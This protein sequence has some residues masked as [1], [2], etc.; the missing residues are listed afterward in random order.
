[1]DL[2]AKTVLGMLGKVHFLIPQ[3]NSNPAL[4]GLYLEI[5]PHGMTMTTTDGHSLAQAGTMRYNLQD[6]RRWLI[7]RRAIFEVKKLL[8]NAQDVT[9]FLGLCGN[10]LVFSGETFNFFT[11]LLVDPFPEY[12]AILERSEFLPAVVDRAE[13]VKTLRRSSCLLSGQFIATNFGFTQEALHVSIENKEVG[14]LAEKLSLDDFNGDAVDIRFYAPYLLSGLQV[15]GE[16]K[17]KFFL[18]NATKPIVFESDQDDIHLVYLVMPV[19]PV[20]TARD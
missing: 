14:A 12:A 15:F 1:M 5:T 8:E 11:K 4:N 16:E 7:P 20:A 3:N 10:Q 6:A 19:C 17:I 13:L 9:M 18:K 2:D